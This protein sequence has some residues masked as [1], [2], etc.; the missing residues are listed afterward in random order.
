M[1]VHAHRRGLQPRALGYLRPGHALDESEHKCL[2]VGFGQRAYD[3]ERLARLR[4]AAR[5]ARESLVQLFGLARAAVEVGRAVARDHRDPR[6]EARSV[7]QG[8]ELAEGDEENVLHEI[9]DF[10]VRDAR[11]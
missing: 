1:Q 11:E 8:A 4:L 6:A 7:A 2:A 5:A 10:V 9:A 3:F